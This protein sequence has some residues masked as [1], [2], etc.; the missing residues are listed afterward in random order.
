MP[1]KKELRMQSSVKVVREDD[2]CMAIRCKRE[3]LS[4][5][6]GN[7]LRIYVEGFWGND[8]DDGCSL[9]IEYYDKK[10]RVYV[11]GGEGKLVEIP[12]DPDL[13][14]ALD[15]PIEQLPLLITS[16]DEKVLEIVT[17]RLNKG[18]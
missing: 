13:A 2:E 15:C 16:K 14:H 1:I 5:E 10:L 6:K 4:P 12:E 8:D 18:V 17:E 3:D 11:Y 9:Y 7:A